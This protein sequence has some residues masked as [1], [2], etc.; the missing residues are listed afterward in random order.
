[1]P[2][3]GEG[4]RN[5]GRRG[6]APPLVAAAADEAWRALRASMG[7]PAPA[8]HRACLPALVPQLPWVATPVKD[9]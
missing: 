5:E 3:R 4:E 1:M 6:V 8:C 9:N 7:G 2:R